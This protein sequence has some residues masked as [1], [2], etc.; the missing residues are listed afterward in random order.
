MIDLFGW[1]CVQSTHST[2]AHAYKISNTIWRIFIH[3]FT[4]CEIEREIERLIH[5]TQCQSVHRCVMLSMD[6]FILWS[7]RRLRQEIGAYSIIMQ[8][9]IDNHTKHIHTHTHWWPPQH[10][11]WMWKFFNITIICFIAAVVRVTIAAF[12]HACMHTT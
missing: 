4:V 11:C 5:A 3:V 7:I 2:Y 8:I 9:K 1:F 10:L 12:L 6:T